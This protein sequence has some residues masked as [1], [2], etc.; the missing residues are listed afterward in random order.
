MARVASKFSL[1]G[2]NFDFGIRLR[3]QKMGECQRLQS[4]Y[5]GFT[6][7]RDRSALPHLSR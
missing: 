1:F 2:Q 3:L 4:E 5:E 6:R 7:F